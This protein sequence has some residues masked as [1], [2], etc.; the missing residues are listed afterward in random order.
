[1]RVILV[2]FLLTFLPKSFF[3]QVGP[4]NPAT[5]VNDAS[6]GTFTWTNPTNCF[7][8]NDARATQSVQGL[9][10]YLKATNFGFAIGVANNIDGIRV[11]IERSTVGS[12]DVAI[13]SGWQYGL[14]RSAAIPAGRNRLLVFCPGFENG[15]GVVKSLTSVTY[16]GQAMTRAAISTTGTAGGFSGTVEI[17]ILNEAG[18]AAAT[19]NNFVITES[20]GAQT[21][22]VRWQGASVVFQHVDQLV[23][24]L[25]SAT[26]AINGGTNPITSSAI[27]VL[28]GSMA[29]S[30]VMC[31]AI[32]ASNPA[33]GS[34]NVSF[35]PQTAGY[36]EGIDSYTCNGSC[37]NTSGAAFEVATA[38]FAAIGTSAPSFSFQGT[39]N[40]TALAVIILQR[41]RELD[42]NVQIVRNGVIQPT[43]LALTNTA[44]PETDAYQSYGGPTNLWGASWAPPL[45]NNNNFGVAISARTQ[46]GTAAIDHIRITVFLTSVLPIE[47]LGFDATKN[48][49]SVDCNWSTA[50]EIRSSH[51]EIERSADGINFEKIGR[52][53]AAGES[54]SFKHYEFKDENPEEGINY[55]RLKKVDIDN[56]YDYSTVKAVKF[57]K[58]DE[59]IIYPN[60]GYNLFTIEER[61]FKSGTITIFTEDGKLVKEVEHPNSHKFMLNL[62]DVADGTYF[63]VLEEN[64]LRKVKKVIKQSREQ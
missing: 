51:F 58:E 54:Y 40:R 18:I 32:P 19:S 17:W 49:G 52:I 45:I 61:D 56:S 12:S 2:L 46:N 1:M 62:S 20:A 25:N 57:E 26:V 55:Y 42:V 44:W 43:N 16:G 37:C 8:S 15:G 29:V 34:S 3:S 5:A 27:G 60:P 35:I 21:E 28:K 4:N 24:V 6:A 59:L 41:A 36:T 11:D 33:C 38:P 23:P 39:P 13:L 53:E 50:T 63:V 64:G 31:G 22:I 9:S 48:L 7:T 30:V 47:L 10:H 14:S